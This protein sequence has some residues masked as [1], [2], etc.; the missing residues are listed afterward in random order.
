MISDSSIYINFKF[1]PL[2]R[3]LGT[4]LRNDGGGYES[5]VRGSR[6]DMRSARESVAATAGQRRGGSQ[7]LAEGKLPQTGL[8]DS[9]QRGQGVRGQFQ[10]GPKAV[11]E[12]TYQSSKGE[13]T[14]P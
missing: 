4:G 5:H 7:G 11:G 1:P 13:R 9:L 8:T 14:I 2:L 12:V 10:K 3:S 6:P